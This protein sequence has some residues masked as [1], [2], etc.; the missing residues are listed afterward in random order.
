MVYQS[1][2]DINSIPLDPDII[3]SKLVFE[4]LQPS[5]VTTELDEITDS[6]EG[7]ELILCAGHLDVQCG[8]ALFSG[9]TTNLVVLTDTWLYFFSL[10]KELASSLT[11]SNSNG[12]SQVDTGE[13]ETEGAPDRKS[14][15]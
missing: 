7:G 6:M 3:N 13:Q 12:V 15:V 10:K 1:V 14:V 5:S 9:K 4:F 2:W 11:S 8:G